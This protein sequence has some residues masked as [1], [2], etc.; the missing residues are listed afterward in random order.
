MVLEEKLWP[1]LVL[2]LRGSPLPWELE[3]DLDAL[4]LRLHRREKSV[5]VVD[6]RHGEAASPELRHRYAEWLKQHEP[7]I[8]EHSLGCAFVLTSPAVR[9]SLH[10]ILALRP[11]PIPHTLAPT[12]EAGLEWAADR[13]EGA[14]LT[15]QALRV[16]GAHGLS[17]GARGGSSPGHP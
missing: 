4:S 16:R 9:L 15:L 13:L 2:R 5:C 1:L 8:R 12:L 17:R 3:R 14:G 7:L 6:A 11:L 10:V